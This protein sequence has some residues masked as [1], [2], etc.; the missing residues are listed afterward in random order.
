MSTDSFR[1]EGDALAGP[2][3]HY[4]RLARDGVRILWAS[5]LPAAAA[6]AVCLVFESTAFMLLTPQYTGEATIKVDFVRS[7]TL[8]EGQ[9]LQSTASVD[10]AAE[11]ASAAR[12]LRSRTVAS[13]VVTALRLDENPEYTRPSRSERAIA[14]ARSVLAAVFSRI[15]IALDFPLPPTPHDCAVDRFMGQVSVT[16]DTRSYLITIGVTDTEPDR[17]AELANLVA[18]EYL[19]DRFLQHAKQAYS[20]AE[21]EFA[22]AA[23]V[24]GPRHP[25]YVAARENVMRLK[26]ELPS[27]AVARTQ[28]LV[29]FAGGQYLI[30]AAPVTRPSWPNPFRF[31]ALGTT[32]SL[33]L[34][35][36]LLWLGNRRGVGFVR[37]KAEP[38]RD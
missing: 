20:A 33:A 16:N 31:F 30:P 18:S 14:T 7:E 1:F 4:A 24:Y 23:S 19:R 38:Y 21:R 5:R 12:I 17:A 32:A 9:R 35:A 13:N 37:P 15:G 28:R 11:V 3:E 2:R 34:I 25:K 26:E 8:T 36:A 29:E 10:A 6:L 27:A 22:A